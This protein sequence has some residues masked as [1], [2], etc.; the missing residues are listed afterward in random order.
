MR[1]R[2]RVQLYASAGQD[3]KVDANICGFS[4]SLVMGLVVAADAQPLFLAELDHY[5]FINKSNQSYS[6]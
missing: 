3:R 2:T 1:R 6:T 4:D 5:S